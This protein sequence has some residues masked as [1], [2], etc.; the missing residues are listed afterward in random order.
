M[1]HYVVV[2]DW[3]SE[4]DNGCNVLGVGHS[5]DEAKEI[6]QD[7]VGEE[8][9]M[10]ESNEWEIYEDCDVEFDAGEGGYYNNNH[11]R[12]FIQEVM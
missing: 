3:T 11:S 8:K 10:A 5:L 7:A 6:F 12:L 9:E 1:N 4:G 2:L